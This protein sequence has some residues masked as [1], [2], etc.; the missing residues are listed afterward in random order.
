MFANGEPPLKV[1]GIPV[2]EDNKYDL[3]ENLRQ[4][5]RN[6]ERE[7][8]KEEKIN[9]NFERLVEFVNLLGQIDSFL[10]A[11]TKNI[12]KK[13]AVLTREEEEMY[14]NYNK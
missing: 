6:E 1:K 2:K 14:N 3:L 12:I 10:S 9:K 11:R 7:L 4:Q 13:L 8:Q 5:I